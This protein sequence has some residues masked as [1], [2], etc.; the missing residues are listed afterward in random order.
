MYIIT[1]AQVRRARVRN[2]ITGKYVNVDAAIL[3]SAQYVWLYDPPGINGIVRDGEGN[4]MRSYIVATGLEEALEN[5][6][7]EASPDAP[8]SVRAAEASAKAAAEARHAE[9]QRVADQKVAEAKSEVK[10][11]EARANAAAEAAKVAA[12]NA[13]LAE[14]DAKTDI[15]NPPRA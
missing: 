15:G 14:S 7:T 4:P 1:T 5:G 6:F 8:E 2:E 3:L 9:V 13:K 10:R 12:E 11:A